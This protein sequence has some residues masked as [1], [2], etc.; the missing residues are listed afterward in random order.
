MSPAR[1]GPWEVRI[2]D[3]MRTGDGRRIWVTA[4]LVNHAAVVSMPEPRGLKPV[5]RCLGNHALATSEIFR[6][7]ED[8]ATVYRPVVQPGDEVRIRFLFDGLPPDRRPA[9]LV[10]GD[11]ADA[12]LWPAPDRITT[13]RGPRRD[14]RR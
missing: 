2:E 12:R 8:R 7:E 1:L 10:L 11:G 6:V 14:Y 3:W 9:H 5:L 4:L 13:G